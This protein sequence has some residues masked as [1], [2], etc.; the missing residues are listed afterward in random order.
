MIDRMPPMDPATMNEAQKKAA[1]DL[2]A[3]PRK[4]VFG[5]FIA[6]LRSPVLMDRL[7]RVGEYLRFNNTIPPRLN[8]FAMLITARHV[9]NQFE[10]A[11]HHP[12][13]IKAG[14]ARETIEAVGRGERPATMAPDEALVHDFCTELLRTYEVCDAVYARAVA[15][16]GE[17]GVVDL[18][19]TV[20]YFITVCL[21]M[22]TARTPRP[23]SDVA[24]LPP[25]A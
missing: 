17:Q 1:A 18:V 25:L 10:W 16:F 15:Q 24:P 22:N 23:A 21:V 14:V 13:A 20:G 5:P 11:L 2:V 6:L 19:G 12:L 8:E 4:G 7:Q 3:G 9:T